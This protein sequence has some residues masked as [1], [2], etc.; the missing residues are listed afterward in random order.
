MY[1]MNIIKYTTKFRKGNFIKFMTD[2]QYIS[3]SE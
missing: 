2:K 3:K 1:R